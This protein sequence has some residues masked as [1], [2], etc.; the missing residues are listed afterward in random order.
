VTVAK[1]AQK[2]AEQE[3]AVPVTIPAQESQLAVRESMDIDP[4]TGAKIRVGMP[5]QSDE[6]LVQEFL[7]WLQESADSATE[8]SMAMLASQ[9][10]VSLT[11]ESVAE[12]LKEKTTINGRDFIG[13]PFLATGFTIREGKFE[14]E[15]IPFYASIDAQHPNYPEGFVVN[16]GGM[17]IL[18]HLQTL[19]RLQAFPLAICVT[20]KPTRKGRTVLSFEIVKQ[21]PQ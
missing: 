15:D 6:D 11:A 10:R 16:C 7:V 14:D 9:L 3:E 5:E 21:N 1:A 12:A 13:I 2:K 18:V 17:K 19:E 20:G 8:D 4:N